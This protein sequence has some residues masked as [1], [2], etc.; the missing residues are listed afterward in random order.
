MENI[1]KYTVFTL[2]LCG[3]LCMPQYPLRA[4]ETY[5]VGTVMTTATFRWNN[6]NWFTE[7]HPK[8]ASFTIQDDG[9]AYGLTE[10]GVSFAQENVPNALGIR[11]QRFSMQDHYHFI[12][13]GKDIYTF[14]Q[15][16]TEL[17]RIYIEGTQA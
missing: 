17:A 5:T 10:T 12:I 15:L 8:V 16:S 9:S 3:I 13:E 14:E 7:P 11:V 6:E 2:A 4:L 1:T